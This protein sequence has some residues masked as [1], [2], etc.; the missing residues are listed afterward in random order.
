[1]SRDEARRILYETID[2]LNQQL[3]A[4]KRLAKAPDTVIVG[5]S[6]SLD[7]LGIVTFIVALEDKAGELLGAPLQLLDDSLLIEPDSPL[8]TIETLTSYLMTMARE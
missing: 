5:A 7:S 2:V 4:A 3:P 1:M 6:G 8:R